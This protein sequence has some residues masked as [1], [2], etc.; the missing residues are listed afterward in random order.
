MS[1]LELIAGLLVAGLGGVLISL[2]E[3]LGAQA[4][5]VGHGVTPLAYGAVG[6]VLVVFGL[7]VVLR[8]VG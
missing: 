6:A 5:A 8:A 1:A 3:R 2:R 7:S 4:R